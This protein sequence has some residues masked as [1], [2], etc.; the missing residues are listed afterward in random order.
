VKGKIYCGGFA[1]SGDANFLLVRG[2]RDCEI[3]AQTI[4]QV[5]SECSAYDSRYAGEEVRC[6]TFNN[7]YYLGGAGD[8]DRCVSAKNAITHAVYEFTEFDG[9]HEGTTFDTI[10]SLPT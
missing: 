10:C 6:Q 7:N 9:G 4:N 8:T 2:Q 1:H 3:Q 5:L